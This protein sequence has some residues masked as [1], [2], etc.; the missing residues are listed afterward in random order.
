MLLTV[1]LALMILS[2]NAA[3]TINSTKSDTNTVYYIGNT[4]SVF[5]NGYILCDSDTPTCHIECNADY[6]CEQATI[7]ATFSDHLYLECNNRYSCR[8]ITVY[9]PSNSSNIHCNEYYSCHLGT[10][11]LSDTPFVHM[12]CG[13]VDGKTSYSCASSE[14]DVA[15]SYSVDIECTHSRSCEFDINATFVGD[16]IRVLCNDSSSCNAITVH[17][18]QANQVH[19]ACNGDVRSSC[20]GLSVFCPSQYENQCNLDCGT[21]N[22]QACTL[23]VYTTDNYTDGFLNISI[24]SC[25]V[26]SDPACASISMHC[27]DS[28]GVSTYYYN[29]NITQSSCSNY[30]CCPITDYQLDIG[31]NEGADC[32]VNCT[33]NDPFDVD[34]YSAV[35]DAT[36]STSLTLYCESAASCR[37]AFVSCPMDG[38]CNIICKGDS[39]CFF[40]H[41]NATLSA[42]T[43]VS[44]GAGSD[45][46]KYV[47]FYLS[48]NTNVHIVCDTDGSCYGV[49][50]DVSNSE[51]VNII[52]NGGCG[53]GNSH[54][55][56][57]NTTTT[58]ISCSQSGSCSGL[59]VYGKDAETVTMNCEASGSCW[60]AFL[61]CPIEDGSC[62]LNCK[63]SQSTTGSCTNTWIKLDGTYLTGY[64]Y[65]PL[66]LS[67]PS[68]A[69]DCA[70]ITFDCEHYDVVSGGTPYTD[71]EWNAFAQQY[72]C[73]DHSCCP[74]YTEIL[75]EKGQDCYIQ[76][77]DT[78]S[79][80]CSNAIIDAK[81]A[82]SLTVDCI[83]GQCRGARFECPSASNTSC[84]IN[85]DTPLACQ[86]AAFSSNGATDIN[87]QC[88][89]YSACDYMQIDITS[90]RNV[91]HMNCSQSGCVAVEFMN[92]GVDSVSNIMCDS[93]PSSSFRFNLSKTI[94]VECNDVYAC[95]RT[96]FY[97]G[98]GGDVT[99]DCTAESACSRIRLYV[100]EVDSF[101]LTAHVNNSFGSTSDSI[102]KPPSHIE[103]GTHITCGA[104]KACY[105]FRYGGIIDFVNDWLDMQCSS[106]V[107]GCS[108]D[109]TVEC[110]DGQL[111]KETIVSY[112]GDE[113]VCDPTSQ[114]MFCC[115]YGDTGT[116]R[117]PQETEQ[118][119]GPEQTEATQSP[120]QTS[121]NSTDTADT[122]DIGA[123]IVSTKAI[124]G[125]DDDDGASCL[126][127]TIS[128]L[129]IILFYFVCC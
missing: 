114:S 116:T 33:Q 27:M 13:G 11:E 128:V 117:T 25:P 112:N 51:N 39:S 21:G 99:F 127:V 96:E 18:L 47:R 105:N 80:L 97:G 36:K 90:E 22:E 122:T 4:S 91:V 24:D 95:T 88:T 87:I 84:H 53:G 6:A 57:Y 49:E 118:T 12:L 65:S 129:F 5:K 46:C 100:S 38:D 69:Y 93:C 23:G 72:E 73:S 123:T 113:Y 74:V 98:S 76:C 119:Q 82:T 81:D 62:H 86:Y 92:Y 104:E 70:D 41:L 30:E 121:T 35:I 67:C 63:D 54:V 77:N 34:C 15:R 115:P 101:A 71:Y 85:C 2:M 59:I 45:S 42:N 64:E 94:S 108:D 32:V 83:D 50:I 111:W 58:D 55:Y 79:L 37:F 19:I 102:L 1:L 66:N 61:F 8:Q 16:S 124:H 52:C 26:S 40:L 3:Q 43:S 75:C 31:C 126:S 48:N 10:F 17:A 9:G 106:T 68:N 14:M 120:Q 107:N 109:V 103:S 60:N 44:C 78:G 89:D 28:G 110:L 56:A 20:G 29:P 125:G 7:N